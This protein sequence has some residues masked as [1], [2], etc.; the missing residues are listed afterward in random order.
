MGVFVIN[1]WLWA[2]I[3]GENEN[4]GRRQYEAAVFVEAI[5]QSEHQLIIVEHSKFDDK[6]WATCKSPTFATKMLVVNFLK[7]RYDLDRCRLLHINQLA[8]LPDDLRA[9]VKEHD[10]YL[11]RALLTAPE[12]ILVTTDGDLCKALKELP[13]RCI[14]R[15]EF[16]RDY[17]GISS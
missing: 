4:Q 2:D 1:E 6:A 7:L 13:E 11:V 8:E 17:F 3:Q 12:S 10:H 5:L 9:S 14:S 15:E 16:L